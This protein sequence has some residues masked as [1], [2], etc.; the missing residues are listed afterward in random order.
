MDICRRLDVDVRISQQ[1]WGARLDREPAD[2]LRN[3]KPTVVIVE[4]PAPETEKRLR[5]DGHQVVVVDHHSYP[6]RGLDR[7]QPQSSLEQVAQILDYSLTRREMAVAIND[8]S[9]IFGLL[10]SGYSI[11]EILEIRRFDLEAQ[12]IPAEDIEKVKSQLQEAPVR[13]GIKI[14]RTNVKSAGFAQDFLVLENPK[15]VKDLLILSGEPIRKAAFY[16][17]P[18][19]IEKL[20]DLAEWMGGSGRSRFWGTSHPDVPEIFR[21]LGIEG[22]TDM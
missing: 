19:K 20:A 16:G 22:S 6:G 21:R 5:A 10:D 14:L 9:Y 2:N 18:K 13:A 7:T 1:P 17:D 12:G 15:E 8:R 4:M 3:L 11:A